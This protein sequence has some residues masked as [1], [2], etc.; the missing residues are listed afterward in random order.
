MND[1]SYVKKTIVY[2]VILIFL[3]IAFV[4]FNV[5]KNNSSKE[6]DKDFCKFTKE[7]YMTTFLSSSQLSSL[8]EDII[9]YLKSIDYT[10][11]E[12]NEIEFQKTTLSN[13]T[14][15]YFFFLL[16]DNDETLYSTYY[17]K[18]HNKISDDYIWCGDRINFD[19]IDETLDV[20][21]LEIIDPSKYEEYALN[22]SVSEEEPDGEDIDYSDE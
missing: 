4:L 10:D 21:Y 15:I 18:S 11:K 19:Y 6:V 8:E 9:E 2:A 14:K 7:N 3:I 5:F 12:I 1:S 13:S 22:K 16:D 20:A 17:D